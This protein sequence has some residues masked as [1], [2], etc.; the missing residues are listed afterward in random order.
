[1]VNTVWG[2][3]ELARHR[4][5][6]AREAFPT[7]ISEDSPLGSQ[8][9]GLGLALFRRNQT[10]AAVAEYRQAPLLEPEVSLYS[11]LL[12]T[13]YRPLG[14]FF[15]DWRGWIHLLLLALA[16]PFNA[17]LAQETGQI[18]SVLGT[19]EVLRERRWQALA[20]GATLSAG[21]TVRTGEGS[22][23]AIQLS[24]GSQIKINANSRLEF[25]QIAPPCLLYTSR[26]V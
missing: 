21:E 20:T 2:F 22:R 1:M 26:C 24:N 8:H 14:Q 12:Y 16:L 23:A 3:L 17:A 4:I 15:S 6:G 5:D 13:A 25:R 18:V 19:V 10:E 7:A 11:C 9:L